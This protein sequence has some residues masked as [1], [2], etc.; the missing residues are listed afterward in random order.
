MASPGHR[1]K[2][3]APIAEPEEVTDGSVQASNASLAMEQQPRIATIESSSAAAP[4]RDEP[5]VHMSFGPEHL[6][7][8]VRRPLSALGHSLRRLWQGERVPGATELERGR[9]SSD[10]AGEEEEEDEQR[11]KEN[12]GSL[13]RSLRRFRH[14]F[15]P[16]FRV[17]AG[18]EAPEAQESEFY[19]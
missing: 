2:G 8:Q 12:N 10:M 19:K 16:P 6:L 1:R 3:A 4:T 14:R 18:S 15:C 5:D 11:F 17:V 13:C 7:Q 9:G